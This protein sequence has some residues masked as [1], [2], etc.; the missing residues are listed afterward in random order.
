M[1]GGLGIVKKHCQIEY[2]A[3]TKLTSLLPN[4]DDPDKNKTHL[5]GKVVLEQTILS[6]NDRILFGNHNYFL[7]VVPGEPESEE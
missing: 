6:H 2:D 4:P 3:E 5:N 1:I 7:F